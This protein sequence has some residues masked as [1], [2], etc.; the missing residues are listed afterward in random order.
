MTELKKK[1]S[2]MILPKIDVSNIMN[3]SEEEMVNE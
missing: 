1:N 3:N 2:S